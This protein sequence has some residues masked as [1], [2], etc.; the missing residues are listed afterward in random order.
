[1]NFARPGRLR[2][3][4]LALLGL[5][6][7]LGQPL[8]A[9]TYD[10]VLANGRVMDPESGLDAVRFVGINGGRIAA[11]SS[12]PLTGRT[13]VDVR[14]L[15]VGPGFVDL[16]AHGQDPF[17]SRLQA[18]DGVT[19]A[20]ELEGGTGDVGDWYG[21]R[22]GKAVI[23][24]GA[25]M[26]HG[27]ARAA[28]ITD[29]VADGPGAIYRNATAEEIGRIAER[30]RQGLR[31]GALGI[32]Y[33]IQYMPGA[34]RGEIVRMFQVAA[35][36]GVTNFVHDR[37][38]SVKEPGSSVEAVQE[39]IAAS[40]VSGAPVH[41]VH[42]GSSGLGQVPEILE[43]I[44]GAR[45]H[46]VD[47]ST[48]VYPYTAASTDIRAAIFD[49]GWRERL[50]ADYSDIEWVAT[51]ERLNA[52]TWVTRRAEGGM[53]IAHV[54]PEAGVDFAVGHPLVM[55]ASDGVE[56]RNGRAHPRGAGS[57]ARVLG[58][59]VRE[60]KT[61][62]L[63]EA[64][65]KMSLMPARRLESVVP[66][67]KTKGRVAVGADADLTIFDPERVIDRATFAEPAQASAGIVHVLVNGTF[68]V[69]NEALVDGATPGVAIRRPTP[70][71]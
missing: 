12:T 11:I 24:F 65:R 58:R 5:A 56:F 15:V 45:K 1:M 54:I 66:Q 59:Y 19:T 21:S 37:F 36:F 48:E 3:L 62:T 51:G 32:G 61:L 16:H 39:L 30:V 7:G 9:Q 57:Y 26:S 70:I 6:T 67:M 42:V 20:L 4:L 46:G 18:R 50:G 52:Q 69:R 49:D 25:T 63:M 31:A 29:Q 27:D 23:N 55:I 68:V 71:P 44:A 33:G 43:M 41:M 14:G 2:V 10:L 22:V 53:I 64:L 17:S 13:V 47:I 8:L 28:I 40:A 35:E 38:A 60:K 34:T